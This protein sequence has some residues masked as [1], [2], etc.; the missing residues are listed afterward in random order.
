VT[1]FP[2]GQG[3]DGMAPCAA[4]EVWVWRASPLAVTFGGFFPRG[5]K[6][7]RIAVW[8]AIAA[9]ASRQ[10]AEEEAGHPLP[11]WGG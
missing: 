2:H 4:V 7:W 10:A 5:D 1:A 6:Q 8:L 9:E 11:P 3:E